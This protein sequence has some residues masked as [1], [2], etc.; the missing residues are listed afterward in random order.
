MFITSSWLFS[1]QYFKARVLCRQET[2]FCSL[3]Y[4]FQIY[5]KLGIKYMQNR[6]IISKLYVTL[7]K[8]QV[9]KCCIL[10]L[11]FLSLLIPSSKTCLALARYCPNV[12]G[13]Q[14]KT[15]R[16]LFKVEL[17][18]PKNFL[19]LEDKIVTCIKSISNL[20]GILLV[21]EK[22]CC[23]LFLEGETRA[24]FSLCQVPCANGN[25]G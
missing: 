23:P 1:L 18:F 25:D 17:L 7:T 3:L 14:C 12:W 21:W 13:G 9:N 4:L 22:R 5:T 8:R 11:G 6:S 19:F 10:T 20:Q 24:W 2:Q 16:Y 15:P